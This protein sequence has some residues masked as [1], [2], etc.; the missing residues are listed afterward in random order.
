MFVPRVN[1]LLSPFD[2]KVVFWTELF[3]SSEA[4]GKD[5]GTLAPTPHHSHW[6]PGHVAE[7]FALLCALA[8]MSFLLSQ[9]TMYWSLQSYDPRW[10]FLVRSWYVTYLL[11][12]KTGC[13]DQDVLCYSMNTWSTVWP[14]ILSWVVSLLDGPHEKSFGQYTIRFIFPYVGFR[15]HPQRPLNRFSKVSFLRKPWNTISTTESAFCQAKYKHVLECYLE[16]PQEYRFLWK[17]L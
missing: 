1:S 10:D 9:C 13:R 16:S 8:M 14:K 3:R 4:P 15:R 5:F 2:L 17:W 6:L 11:Q 7:W 12:Y